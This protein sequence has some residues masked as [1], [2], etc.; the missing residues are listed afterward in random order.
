MIERE[1]RLLLQRAARAFGLCG[2]LLAALCLSLPGVVDADVLPSVL[3]LLIAQAGA[4]VMVGRSSHLGWV[5]LTI[6]LGFGALALAQLPWGQGTSLALPLSLAPLGAAGLAGVGMVL[7]E[8]TVRWLVWAAGTLGSS[9]LV[10]TAGP[11]GGLIST[12]AIATLASWVI[13]LI[14]GTRVTVGVERALRRIHRIGRDEG[15]RHLP[16][17]FDQHRVDP[18]PFQRLEHRIDGRPTL[19]VSVEPLDQRAAHRARLGGRQDQRPLTRQLRR[20]RHPKAA[21]QHHAQRLVHRSARQTHGQSRI[22]GQHR[23]NACQHRV[24]GGP[25]TMTLFARRL[26]GDPLGLARRGRDAAVQRGRQFQGDAH[27][28][29]LSESLNPSAPRNFA[30][31]PVCRKSL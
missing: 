3:I 13:M 26:S 8:G 22:V 19:A 25:Q 5:V 7:S 11:T 18:V 24:M 10:A 23:L 2:V 27:H 15:R 1:R 16:A 30:K 29:S 12:P 31:S 14:I 17:A 21:V 20:L 28:R 9:L 4:L 6:V